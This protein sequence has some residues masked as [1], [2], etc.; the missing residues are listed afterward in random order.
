MMPIDRDPIPR[1]AERQGN[2][3]KTGT[4]ERIVRGRHETVPTVMVIKAD[5]QTAADRYI[6]HFATCTNPQ[7]FR[8][9]R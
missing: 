7:R 9:N 3:I 2:L 8:R 6:S 4:T 1:D 5:D